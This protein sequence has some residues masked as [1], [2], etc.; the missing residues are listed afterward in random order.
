MIEPLRV[1]VPLVLAQLHLESDG[2]VATTILM[3]AL[4][5]IGLPEKASKMLF[6]CGHFYRKWNALWTLLWKQHP[7]CVYFQP[8][9]KDG[10]F[11]PQFSNRQ[12]R[13]TS[14]E[15][16]PNSTHVRL[17]PR[18]VGREY[19]ISVSPLYNFSVERWRR[20]AQMR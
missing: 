5:S 15:P 20:P 12:T 7:W 3:G 18:V 9:H 11:Q 14:D 19:K 10:P 17:H 13:Q 8:L 6:L 16:Q 4:I 1:I 2:A